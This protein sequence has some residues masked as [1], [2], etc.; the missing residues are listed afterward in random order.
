MNKLKIVMRAETTLTTRIRNEVKVRDVISTKLIHCIST[1]LIHCVETHMLITES[2][3]TNSAINR[4]ELLV[5][6]VFW[7]RSIES[8]QKR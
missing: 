7:S 4:F 3:A 2:R 6:L 5:D 1:K 8:R